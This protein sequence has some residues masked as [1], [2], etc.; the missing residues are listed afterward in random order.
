VIRALLFDFDGL[1][2]DTEGP[3]YRAWVEVYERHGHDLTL[4]LWSAAIGTIDGFDPVRHLADLGVTVDADAQEARRRRD[5]DLCDVEELRPGV[6]E[7]LE[8]AE[9]SGLAKAIVSSSS[10]WWIERHLQHRGLLDRFDAVV[11][12][13]GDTA[14]A[15]PRP[16]LYLDALDRL[17]IAP[18]DGVA[19][20]DSPNG[21]A[22]AK[23]AGLYTIAV[24]N[25]ITGLLDLSQADRV[26]GSL[27]EIDVHELEQELQARR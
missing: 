4:D 6:T 14:R 12:A 7:L 27:E 20:E 24:P 25:E 22:G 26:V 11:C 8:A 16:A 19:F 3:S 21:V 10:D 13:N 18:D 15:K 1:L 23:A 17:R 2:L 9:A 5:L